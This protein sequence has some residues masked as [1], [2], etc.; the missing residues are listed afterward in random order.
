MDNREGVCERRLSGLNVLASRSDD[1]SFIP[2]THIVEGEN[3]FLQVVLW[4]LYES[5]YAG[6][7]VHTDI[8][9]ANKC[10]NNNDS[11]KLKES[12]DMG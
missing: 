4:F 8:P 10:N 7:R 11:S 9:T 12:D 1:L 3:G 6:V 2:G 5:C